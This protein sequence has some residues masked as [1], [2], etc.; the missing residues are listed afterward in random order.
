MANNLVPLN[1][2]INDTELHNNNKKIKGTPKN[3]L[4]IVA[5]RCIKAATGKFIYNSAIKLQTITTAF[6]ALYPSHKF[7]V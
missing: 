3:V 4:L 7:I 2:G 5:A 1:Q 6:M